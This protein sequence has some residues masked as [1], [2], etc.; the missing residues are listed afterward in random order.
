MMLIPCPHCGQRDEHEFTYG[1]DA[2]VLRPADPEA[3]SD[4]E[5]TSFLF[6]RDNPLGAHREHWFHRFGCRRW[7]TIERD[8][9][10]HHIAAPRGGAS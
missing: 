7:I 3:L 5:W 8:T 2:T 9:L 1:G 10:N 4:K 6:L